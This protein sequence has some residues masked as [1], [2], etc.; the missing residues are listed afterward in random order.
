MNI[1]KLIQAKSIAGTAFL[2]LA[3]TA[4]ATSITYNTNAAGSIFVGG[5]LVLNST[6]GASATLTFTGNP[7]SITGTPSNLDLGDFELVCA[8][9]TT[10][11]V[12]TTSATFG[13]FTFDLQL[14]DTTDGATGLFAGTSSGGTVFSNSSPIDI[15]WAPLQLGPGS[16]NAATGSFGLTDFSIGSF[17]AIVAP[18]SGSPAGDTTI[19]GVVNTI[20]GVPEP[21]TMAMMGGALLGLG[22]LGKRRLKRS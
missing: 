15:F 21:A 20:S 14:T 22:L 1:K 13:S 19:Q 7:G 18:N 4:S 3:A 6:S 5:G 17:T 16:T 8:T 11:A 12:G 10:Q 9:C 2:M